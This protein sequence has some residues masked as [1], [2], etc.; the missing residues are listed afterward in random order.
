M[1]KR[2]VILGSAGML[3]H[4][5]F[6]VF[7]GQTSLHVVGTHIG[8]PTDPFYFNVESGMDGLVRLFA[9]TG[10]PDYVIN[11]IGVLK[12]AIDAENAESV[13]R[14]ARINAV[15]PHQLAAMA[16]KWNF[17]VIQISTD[18]VFAGNREFYVEDAP[19]D[20]TDIYGK[21]KSLGEV[22]LCD[23]FLNLRCSIIG[24]S[25]MQKMGLVEWLLGQPDG[26][27]VSG[28]TNQIW[29]GVSTVQF[30]KLC[31]NIIKQDHFD[32]LRSESA[33]FHF[34]PNEPV[35]KYQL[36]CLIRDTFHRSIRI[37]PAE[38]GFHELRWV[39]KTRYQGLKTLFPHGSEPKDM[40]AELYA[41]ANK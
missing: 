32:V 29:N 30:A 7:S 14:A 21:T 33:V 37:V 18:G 2:V 1:M 28:F 39:L 36:L 22:T 34:A 3:G 13:I 17:R 41:Y 12:G 40:V 9:F 6:K 4:M 35:S 38:S 11:C 23:G 5:V 24:P 26:A 25:P 15:F 16:L 10:A 20:C 19:H 27:Q 31:L 8:D